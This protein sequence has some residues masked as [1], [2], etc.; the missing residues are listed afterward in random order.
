MITKITKAT[1]TNK[2]LM[3]CQIC[4]LIPFIGIYIFTSEPSVIEWIVCILIIGLNVIIAIRVSNRDYSLY[5]DEEANKIILI[6][7]SAV[8]KYEIEDFMNFKLAYIGPYMSNVFKF[9]LLLYKGKQYRIKYFMN[10]LDSYKSI[11]N[12]KNETIVLEE[13]IKN[14]IRHTRG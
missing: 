14:D 2:V 5:V 12:Y 8:E 3:F 10:D 9:Y 4:F 13:K 11:L 6:K 7:G 1:L